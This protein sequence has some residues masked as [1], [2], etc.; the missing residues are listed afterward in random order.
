M[1]R[2]AARIQLSTWTS[3][4]R[5]SKTRKMNR[6]K[7]QQ[8]Q[9]TMLTQTTADRGRYDRAKTWSCRYL[10]KQ[11]GRSSVGAILATEIE[12]RNLKDGILS[13]SLTGG[14]TGPRL[15]L[16][17][18]DSQN[19]WNELSRILD[20]YWQEQPLKDKLRSEEAELAT[21]TY[22]KNHWPKAEG[23]IIHTRQ[24]ILASSVE[25]KFR[26]VD[27]KISN[28]VTKAGNDNPSSTRL[29]QARTWCIKPAKIQLVP[30]QLQLQDRR[31]KISNELILSKIVSS[32]RNWDFTPRWEIKLAGSHCTSLRFP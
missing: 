7:N 3:V 22:F 24:A 31:T 6:R 17:H 11:L 16:K 27:E 2:P 1:T 29:H 32:T 19:M 28:E 10:N 12:G 8:V 15:N 26:R 13:Q 23:R 9:G 25:D 30:E 18:F 20:R 21:R 14:H 4:R 5:F